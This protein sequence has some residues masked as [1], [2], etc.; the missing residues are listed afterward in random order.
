MYYQYNKVRSDE[1]SRCPFCLA[2]DVRTFG[3]LTCPGLRCKLEMY[4]KLLKLTLIP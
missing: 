2:V 3:V 1:T 4:C